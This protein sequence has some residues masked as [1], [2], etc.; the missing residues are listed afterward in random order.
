MTVSSDSRNGLV[1]LNNLGNTCFMNSCLQ[2]LSNTRPLTDYFLKGYFEAEINKINPIG[3]KGKL[4]KN[5]AKFIKGMW[6]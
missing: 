4:A 2:C 1:G 5:Y 3:T 6:C